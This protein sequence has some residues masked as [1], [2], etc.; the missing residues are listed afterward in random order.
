MAGQG[1]AALEL[2]EEVPEL[3]FLLVPTSGSGLLAGSAVAACHMRPQIRVFGVE[4]EAG[5]DTWQSFRKGERVEIPVPK[6]IADGLQVTAPGKLTF[7][8]VRELVEQHAFATDVQQVERRALDGAED[9]EVVRPLEAPALRG[10]AQLRRRHVR[11]VEEAVGALVDRRTR[12]G[13][14][15]RCDRVQSTAYRLGLAM[16][17]LHR[18]AAA[19]P[20]EVRKHHQR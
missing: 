11:G 4:P 20:E 5:N 14:E 2:L 18:L 1:T 19:A 6:T 15:G 9:S 3:D 12:V 16:H 13:C 7:P 8:I 10:G 17:Q